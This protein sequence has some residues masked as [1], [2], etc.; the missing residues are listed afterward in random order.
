MILTVRILIISI[1]A[2]LLAAGIA[3]A[4]CEE[5]AHECAMSITYATKHIKHKPVMQCGTAYC[6][7]PVCHKPLV[8][9]SICREVCLED[10]CHK[11]LQTMSICRE[12]CLEEACHKPLA[13]AELCGGCDCEI[14]LTGERPESCDCSCANCAGS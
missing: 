7:E 12:V 5:C 6:F 2:S 3:N 11:P 14:P 4:S 1:L 10:V 8:P 13:I 9:M